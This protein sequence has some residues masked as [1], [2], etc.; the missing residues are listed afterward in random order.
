M[1]LILKIYFYIDTDEHNFI[2]GKI[3]NDRSENQLMGDMMLL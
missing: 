1:R 3:N 2:L